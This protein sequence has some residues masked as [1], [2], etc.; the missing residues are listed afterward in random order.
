MMHGQPDCTRLTMH[1][2]SSGGEA[3]EA[4]RENEKA[5]NTAFP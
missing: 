4:K 3:A 5:L 1:H 2:F